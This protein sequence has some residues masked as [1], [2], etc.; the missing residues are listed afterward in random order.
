MSTTFT[1]TGVSDL[2]RGLR[3]LSDKLAKGAA[4]SANRKG[5]AVI[6]KAM[7]TA[8]PDGP[9]AEGAIQR[10]KRKN[11]LVRL[12]KHAKIRNHLKVKK[13]KADNATAVRNII[14]AGNAY[15]AGFIEFG[16]I[17]NAALP[18]MRQAMEQNKQAA[19]DA[20]KKELARQI[21][22]RGGTI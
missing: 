16:S 10:R 2:Q 14:S 8:A 17:H 6:Q 4:Q 3:T 15:H 18:F 22:R 11:G 9:T 13:A 7:K 21:V 5:A 12:E 1:L 20:M 19:I